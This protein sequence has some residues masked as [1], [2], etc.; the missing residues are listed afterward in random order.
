M[1]FRFIHNFRILEIL[2]CTEI[3][4]EQLRLISTAKWVAYNGKKRE[5]M[6]KAYLHNSTY[7][8]GGF[9]KKLLELNAANWSV[10]IENIADFVNQI[11][12]EDFNDWV[13]ELDLPED[14]NPR[15]YQRKGAWLAV[16]Y[17]I[18]RGEFATSAGKTL[19]VYLVCRWI[20]DKLI[21]SQERILIVVPSVMLV[22]QTA[23]EFNE[24]SKGQIEADQIYGGSKRNKESQICIGNI[25][26]LINYDSDFFKDFSSIIYDEAH[27]LMTPSYQSVIEFMHEK[28]LKV[29]YSVS[30]TFYGREKAEDFPA[31]SISGPIL[32]RVGAKQLMDE[33][34]IAPLKIIALKLMYSVQT[35]CDYYNAAKCQFSD[36]RYAFEMKFIRTRAS[37][38]L[39]ITKIVTSGQYNQLMLFKSVEYCKAFYKFINIKYPHK[40]CMMIH[41]DIDQATRDEIK[42]LTEKE[43]NVIIVATYA[44]MSTGVSINNLSSLHLCESAKSFIMIRQSIG[45][46]L[47]LHPLK[48]YAMCFDYSDHF[49][50]HDKSWG[51]PKQNITA[52]HFKERKKIY[53]EQKFDDIVEKQIWLN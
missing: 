36:S 8:P 35:C 40:L 51:G 1:I 46:T 41:G 28:D 10:K 11:S 5:N 31:E 33:G 24:F 43:S 20:L 44:C 32:M 45:R 16:K 18:S 23:K 26:S 4:L 27:K 48:E 15:W 3:E 37:R 49:I 34:S 29:I 22:K 12:L 52:K 50:K 14:K 39:E 53:A 42:A 38:F 25:D 9:W 17:R 30:G 21:N 47:R 13:D 7:L 19:I 2:K 6:Q